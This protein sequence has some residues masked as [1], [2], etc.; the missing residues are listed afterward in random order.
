ML[1]EVVENLEG[2]A[3]WICRGLEHDGRHRAN[4]NQLGHAPL[5]LPMPGDIARRLAATG[6]MTDMHGVAQ[7][8]VLH[9]RRDVRSVVVHVVAVAHLRGPAVAAPIMRDDAIAQANEEQGLAI[10]IVTAERPPMVEHDWLGVLRAPVLV[11]DLNAIL[12]GHCAHGHDSAIDGG[13]VD[14]RE[15]S[16]GRRG[17]GSQGCGTHAEQQKI[18]SIRAG[19]PEVFAMAHA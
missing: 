12:G 7:I 4:Q 16:Q 2:K 13:S 10:P 11:E 14:G 1:A 9:Q 17:N 6:R 19:R 8:Q 3:A 15:G 5:H 18:S